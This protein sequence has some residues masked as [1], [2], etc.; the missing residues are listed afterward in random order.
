[1][2][3]RFIHGRKYDLWCTKCKRK[4][5]GTVYRELFEW[6]SRMTCGHHRGIG[7]TKPLDVLEAEGL[8]NQ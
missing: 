4:R 1:M 3:I 8:I 5:P 2:R 7:Y 6:R